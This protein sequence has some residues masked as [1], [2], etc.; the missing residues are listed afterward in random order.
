MKKIQFMVVMI[1]AISMIA[2]IGVAG[3]KG[4][5]EA[6]PSYDS[7]IIYA[8]GYQADMLLY[9]NSSKVSDWRLIPYFDRVYKVTCQEAQVSL[10]SI[11]TWKGHLT[12]KDG[13]CVSTAEPAEWATGNR[14][15]YDRIRAGDGE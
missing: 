11:G 2:G 13:S 1:A 15:N 6:G 8:G 4:V 14:L 7:N 9:K 12:I 3:Q 10:S 5:K